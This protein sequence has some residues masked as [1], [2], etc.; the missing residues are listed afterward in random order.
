MA[1]SPYAAVNA[2]ALV[3]QDARSEHAWVSDVLT[4]ANRAYHTEDR[5][6]LSD[7]EYD[8]HKRRTLTRNSSTSPSVNAFDSDIMR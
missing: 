6:E 5:P 3:L 1:R 7:A 8:A 4:K 2:D